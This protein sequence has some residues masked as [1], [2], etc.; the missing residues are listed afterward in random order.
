MQALRT[1][2]PWNLLY[3]N[4]PIE[5][6]LSDNEKRLR[7]FAGDV[8]EFYGYHIGGDSLKDLALGTYSPR[9][10]GIVEVHKRHLVTFD[11]D[12]QMGIFEPLWARLERKHAFLPR[13]MATTSVLKAGI[14]EF[15][16]DISSLVC[17][18]DSSF[19]PPEVLEHHITQTFPKLEKKRVK[20]K[21]MQDGHSD[22]LDTDFQF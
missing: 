7:D 5:S 18:Y 11:D 4:A 2:H 19:L 22:V 16:N 14:D 17:V 13:V 20:Y 3:G 6:P 12:A 9:E 10:R 15:R 21:P 1:M 8:A